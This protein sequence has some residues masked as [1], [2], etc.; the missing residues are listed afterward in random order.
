[1]YLPKIKNRRFVNAFF[2]MEGTL[3]SAV[4]DENTLSTSLAEQIDCSLFT[5][6]QWKRHIQ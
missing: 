6:V 1:M 4:C 2:D 5:T 3:I